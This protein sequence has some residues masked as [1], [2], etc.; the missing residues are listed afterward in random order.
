MWQ[1]RN[2]DRGDIN[3]WAVALCVAI[4]MAAVA[5]LLVVGG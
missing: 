4:I 3:P 1:H 5:G 2:D